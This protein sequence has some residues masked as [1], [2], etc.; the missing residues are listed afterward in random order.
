MAQKMTTV[1]LRRFNKF[2]LPPISVLLGCVLLLTV[3][4]A[5]STWIDARFW[6]WD[7]PVVFWGWE[8]DLFYIIYQK[9]T[10]GQRPYIDFFIEYPPLVAY[11]IAGPW[12]WLGRWVDIGK[13]EFRGLYILGLGLWLLVAFWWQTSL[14][15][16]IKLPDKK[17]RFMLWL[18]FLHILI[19]YTVIFTRF[20]IFP[21]VLTLVGFSAYLAFLQNSKPIFFVL[22]VL[23]I[24][25]GGFLKIY[26]FVLLPLL[27]LV[28]I[29]Q[30]R[31]RNLVWLGLGFSLI[32][33][34]NLPFVL[35]G[36]ERFQGFLAYQRH[37]SLQIESLYAGFLFL[38]EKF[39]LVSNPL[40]LQSGA[41]AITSRLAFQ[42][43]AWTQPIVVSL[44]VGQFLYLG[45]QLFKVK[46]M[47]ASCQL[48]EI[49]ALQAL[50]YVLT[51]VLFNFIFSP[52]YLVWLIL[53]VPLASFIDWQQPAWLGP[54][55]LA[56]SIL[57]SLLTTLIW[58][59]FYPLLTAKSTWLILVLNLRNLTLLGI[60]LGLTWL[61]FDRLRQLP[62]SKTTAA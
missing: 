54:S 31:Y 34:F 38:L 28:E 58:P 18:T 26:S 10:A 15:R 29:L 62:H 14:F 30:K 47:L 40:E 7:F 4:L 1:I 53:L 46:N 21:A 9:V 20:D 59:L 32:L 8:G 43:G 25:L 50:C 23:L 33:S 56:L 17:T 51:F 12:A 36:Y 6:Q 24:S 37:R 27:V 35:D 41:R 45:W 5:Y 61:T 39:K 2:E 44:L 22:A 42:I 49:L 3:A 19:S 16:Q 11:W 60:W 55:L 48:Q 57:A 52:Q 13:F